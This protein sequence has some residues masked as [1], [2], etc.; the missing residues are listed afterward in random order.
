MKQINPYLF[1]EDGRCRE[2]MEF[3]K[4]CLGGSLEVMTFGD[5]PPGACGENAPTPPKDHVMHASLR[6]DAFA[7]LA[8]DSPMGPV[9]G[10]EN[11]TLNLECSSV[12]ELDGVFAKLSTG[13]SVMAEPH[14]AFWGSRFAMLTD[15]YGFQWMLTCALQK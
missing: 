12:A 14:D 1:F 3:Y 8:S 5:A 11:V 15:R 4:S 10:G 13:G 6:T 2:A 7:L 9:K